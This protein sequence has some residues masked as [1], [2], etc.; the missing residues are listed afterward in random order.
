L[1]ATAG[2]GIR[3]L[4]GKEVTVVPCEERRAGK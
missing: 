3:E 1:F 2:V 4:V